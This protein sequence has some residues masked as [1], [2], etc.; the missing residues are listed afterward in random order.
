M[1]IG[2]ELTPDPAPAPNLAPDHQPDG[3]LYK[4]YRDEVGPERTL[5]IGGVLNARDIGGLLGAQGKVRTG[6]VLRAARLSRLTDEGANTLADL[7]LKTVIDIRTPEERDEEPDRVAGV[8]SLEEVAEARIELLTTLDGL[9]VTSRDLYRYL[10]DSC[11]NSIVK[12]LECLAKP[13][14]LPALVHCHVGKDRTGL[15]IA[16]LL[17]LLD[18]PRELI[19]ADYIASNAGLGSAAYTTVHAEILTWTLEGLAERYGSTR[20]YL[21]A[22][23]LTEETVSA[24]RSALL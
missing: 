3:N 5:T 24:L 8:P 22:H 21:D 19:L 16:L 12:V 7:G 18:V 1:S 10:A 2:A 11:G 15:L 6:R 20:G 14:A 9:P 13:N 23:G 17:E 4:A